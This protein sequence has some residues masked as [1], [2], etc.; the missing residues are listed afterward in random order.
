MS[1][2]TEIKSAIRC[3]HE[4]DLR[5]LREWLNEIDFEAWDRKIK[6]DS[7]SGCL[8]FLKEEA[9][10]EEPARQSLGPGKVFQEIDDF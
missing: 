9:L 6:R 2:V 1:T 10:R 5:E 4:Q 8:D 3:L 7:A